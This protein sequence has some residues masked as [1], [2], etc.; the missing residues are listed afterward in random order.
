MAQY[1]S[2]DCERSWNVVN[3][4]NCRGWRVAYEILDPPDPP[5][6]DDGIFH[7]YRAT[8]NARTVGNIYMS[9]AHW[10]DILYLNS[11]AFIAGEAPNNNILKDNI[12]FKDAASV[13]YVDPNNAM[14]ESEWNAANP[15]ALKSLNHFMGLPLSLIHI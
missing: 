12:Y 1:Y 4:Q 15:Q 5:G 10:L 7:W 2:D 9:P 3:V 6:T 11:S 8:K 14:S 13:T